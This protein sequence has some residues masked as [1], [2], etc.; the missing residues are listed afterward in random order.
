[1]STQG[2]FIEANQRF[3]AQPG[4]ILEGA[5]IVVLINQGSAS[6][7]EIVAGAL[8]DNHR[9]TVVGTRSYGK[10]SVQS[11]IPLGDGRSALKL[12]TAKYFT[13]AGVSIEGTGITPDVPILQPALS[14]SNKEVIINLAEGRNADKNL[15]A[16]LDKQLIKSS[17]VIRTV[18]KIIIT[19][20][21]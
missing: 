12:T 16:S 9:A 15:T 5:P 2:R 21:I 11:L 4:D 10:G 3:E 1:M 7:A 20:S 6:A 8:K 19:K 14:Q 18:L 17:A 13:P